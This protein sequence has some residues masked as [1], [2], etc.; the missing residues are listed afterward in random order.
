MGLF[1][2][3][4]FLKAYAPVRGAVPIFGHNMWIVK[5]G[6][7]TLAECSPLN[8]FIE[9][10][11]PTDILETAVRSH[12]WSVWFT[13]DKTVAHKEF[14]ELPPYPTF[15]TFPEFK[16]GKK[17]RWALRKS[18][19]LKLIVEDGKAVAI[20]HLL[21]KLWE[22]L[23]RSISIEF[24][25]TLEAASVGRTIYA[26]H[27]GHICTGL[28]YLIG[29]NGER[30]MFSLATDPKYRGTDVTS[31]LVAE[32]LRR[33]FEEG[34]PYVDLCGCSVPSIYAF[35][36]HFASTVA[37]RPRYLAVLNPLWHLLWFQMR[38]LF[39]SRSDHIP[40]REQWRSLL[41]DDL[42]RTKTG[43]PTSNPNAVQSHQA[44][45]T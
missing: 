24:Y 28:F 3:D 40:E 23:D 39:R 22:R 14:R 35:K 2:S 7:V 41:V 12:A 17:L 8:G 26:I 29:T 16:P 10:P 36:R 25:L 43:P 31:F 37:W 45:C 9:Q 32:F 4:L 33:S 42:A 6:F 38:H 1:T 44:Y 11:N 19:K 27:D 21:D 13:S 5:R 18:K 15:L 34:T 20:R 30:Y